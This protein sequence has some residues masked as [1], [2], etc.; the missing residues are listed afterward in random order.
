[1]R[2]QSFT[3]RLANQAED[4]AQFNA[5]L[6]KVVPLQV[7]SALVPGNPVIWSILVFYDEDAS[8][9]PTR[10]KAEPTKSIPA[11]SEIKPPAPLELSEA[12][13]ALFDRLRE[14]RAERAKHDNLPP[15]IVAHNQ[16]LEK[17]A[18]ARPASLEELGAIDGFGKRKVEQFG[19]EILRIVAG[20][21]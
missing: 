21:D 19:Q 11:V 9:E 17:V 3:L 15:Y 13:K 18:Q 10:V 2:C 16:T 12:D 1:M 5:F 6:S 7:S 14:W 20:K 8:P 4:L